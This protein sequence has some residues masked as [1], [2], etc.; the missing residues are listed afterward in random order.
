MDKY[1]KQTTIRLSTECWER[2]RLFAA[3][4]DRNTSESTARAI[5]WATEK[6]RRGEWEALARRAKKKAATGV[7]PTS[8]RLSPELKERLRACAAKDKI[9]MVEFV[10]AAIWAYTEG[11]DIEAESRFRASA[12]RAAASRESEEQ[13][14][15]AAA[16][17]VS[18][19]DG[20]RLK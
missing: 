11:V 18:A 6:H 15:S 19:R 9:D 3:V 13:A 7:H 10:Q 14:F 16:P 12:R 17:P 5:E 20:A 8:F 1:W 2:L 4:N